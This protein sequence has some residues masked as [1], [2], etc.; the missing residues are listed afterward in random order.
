MAES[1]DRFSRADSAEIARRRRG[2]NL[3]ILGA[4]AVL[5]VLFYAMAMVK[6]RHL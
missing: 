4:L 2:R 1:P 5:C 6:L 3:A